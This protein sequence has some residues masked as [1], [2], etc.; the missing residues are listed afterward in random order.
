M[1]NGIDPAILAQFQANGWTPP[2][3]ATAVNM[4]AP[5][6]AAAPPPLQASGDVYNSPQMQSLLAPPTPLNPVGGKSKQ[7][8]MQGTETQMANQTAAADTG[9]S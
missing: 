6:P 8:S 3:P 1:A 4:Q 7:Q 5:P 9:G 2:A